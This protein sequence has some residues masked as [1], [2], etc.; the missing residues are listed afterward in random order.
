M[1]LLLF[2]FTTALTCML[3]DLNQ[4]LYSETVNR[5]AEDGFHHYSVKTL[6][7][8]NDRYKKCSAVRC[9]GTA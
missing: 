2:L 7:M 8:V 3:A 1:L 6:M 4:V 9:G 5:L